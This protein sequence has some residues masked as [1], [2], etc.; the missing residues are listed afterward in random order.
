MDG[1]GE[2]GDVVLFCEANGGRDGR[3]SG[4]EGAVE[5]GE[6]NFEVYGVGWGGRL[7]GVRGEDG[8]LDQERIGQG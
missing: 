5:G 6:G 4:F 8:V 2:E 7:D 1:Q 3:L